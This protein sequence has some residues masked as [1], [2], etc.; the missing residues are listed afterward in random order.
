M[1]LVIIVYSGVYVTTMSNTG[2]TRLHRQQGVAFTTQNPQ[3]L[4]RKPAT[5][6]ILGSLT[7][8][9]HHDYR[10]RSRHQDHQPHRHRQGGSSGATTRIAQALSE[11]PLLVC[12]SWSGDN[13]HERTPQ[14]GRRY[15]TDTP[16]QHTRKIKT[17]WQAKRHNCDRSSHSNP[18]PAPAAPTPPPRIAATR[19]TVWS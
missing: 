18:R 10:Q 13:P 1:I 8:S 6:A 11:T 5:Q 2:H 16:T 19:R 7:Q 12:Q 14:H 17:S 4:W 3:N 15:V 9:F